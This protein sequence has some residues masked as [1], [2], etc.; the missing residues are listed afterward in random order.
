[1]N[2]QEEPNRFFLMENDKLAGEVTFTNA[3][4]TMFI[5]D[6]TFV[7]DQFRGQGIA[8][9]LVELVVKK[10]RK[11]NKKIMPLC[12]FAKGEFERKPEYADV[13]N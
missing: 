8:Q 5:I 2:F 1:M 7:D 3:G 6:H 9:K 12:P 13:L 10:A 11:E 4:E